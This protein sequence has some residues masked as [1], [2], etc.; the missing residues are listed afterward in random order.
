M[1]RT[2]KEALAL[3][4]QG[5]P[6][7]KILAK[8]AEHYQ[9]AANARPFGQINN[10]M[11]MN[12]VN[13]LLQKAGMKTMPHGMLDHLAQRLQPEAFKKYF[14]DEYKRTALDAPTSAIS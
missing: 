7:D 12:E 1:H 14:I 5:A 2:A 4:E 8:I 11:F 13:T 6:Q 9:Y 3:I 10:S